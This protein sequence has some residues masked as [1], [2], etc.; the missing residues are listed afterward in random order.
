MVPIL[1]LAAKGFAGGALASGGLNV[2]AQS[3]SILRNNGYS[4]PS[5][6]L[7]CLDVS[8]ILVSA[9]VGGAFGAAGAPFTLVKRLK[10][11]SQAH[12]IAERNQGNAIGKKAN[13]VFVGHVQAITG[14]TL[15]GFSAGASYDNHKRRMDREMGKTN[16]E[17]PQKDNK[18]K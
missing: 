12:K 3:V 11:L 13:E 15:V 8:R 6:L 9:G 16:H 18:C 2:F 14:A 10:T 1:L 7:R 17:C 5:A 4:S